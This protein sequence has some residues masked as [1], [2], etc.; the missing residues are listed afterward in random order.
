MRP[1]VLVGVTVLALVAAVVWWLGSPEPEVEPLARPTD[2]VELRVTAVIDGD[3]IRAVPQVQTEVWREGWDTPVRLLEIDAPERETRQDPAECFA[4]EAT[5]RLGELLPKGSRVWA[6]LD[7]EPVDQYDRVLA[8]LWN[9]DGTFV[10]QAMVEDGFATA[11]LFEPNDRYY[12]DM[13]TAESAA[14]SE[15]RGL[16]GVCR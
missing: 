7:R 6:Q 10:N 16:W 14:K 1:L 9:E 15:S 8:Y 13:T 2:A 3:T 12:E 5:T 4:A 11:V